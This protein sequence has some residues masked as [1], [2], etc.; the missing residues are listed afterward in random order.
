[1]YILK[2]AYDGRHRGFQSQPHGNTVCDNILRA[3]E[4]CGY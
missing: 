1:M 3:L 2:V 4:E